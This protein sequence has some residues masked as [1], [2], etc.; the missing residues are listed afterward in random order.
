MEDNI[1]M[2]DKITKDMTF[3]DVMKKFPKAIQIMAKY[4]LHCVG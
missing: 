4:G 3:G 2:A 1:I